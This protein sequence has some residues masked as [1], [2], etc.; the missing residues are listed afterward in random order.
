MHFPPFIFSCADVGAHRAVSAA[1]CLP[2]SKWQLSRQKVF[3]LDEN[4][5]G[6]WVDF[7]VA[8][9]QP[10]SHCPP[11]VWSCFVFCCS[12]I[13]VESSLSCPC[14]SFYY[15]FFSLPVGRGLCLGKCPAK[16]LSWKLRILTPT[17]L[18]STLL[19]SGCSHRRKRRAY[20]G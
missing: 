12:L 8:A 1:R 14:R 9:S 20:A 17:T 6:Y 2:P 18:H 3:F 7:L 15:Y 10:V 5:L 16:M 19:L 13:G 11:E 4:K